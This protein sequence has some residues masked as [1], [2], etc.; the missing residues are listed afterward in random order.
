MYATV[1]FT[2]VRPRV[3]AHVHPLER[4][5]ARYALSHDG[6]DVPMVSCFFCLHGVPRRR[7]V[8]AAAA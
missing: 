4:L 6:H 8:L 2:L 7:R 3:A 1:P 5:T